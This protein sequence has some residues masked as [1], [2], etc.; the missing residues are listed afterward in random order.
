MS[1]RVFLVTGLAPRPRCGRGLAGDEAGLCSGRVSGQQW[2]H[3]L[4]CRAGTAW[5]G[6]CR[7]G[8]GVTAPG[9]GSG[10]GS[11]Q[12]AWPWLRLGGASEDHTVPG[13]A[14]WPLRSSLIMGCLQQRL[15]LHTR[16]G[17]PSDGG[18]GFMA[19]LCRPPCCGMWQ[20]RAV[21]VQG[22]NSSARRRG[23]SGCS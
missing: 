2:H 10:A 14:L 3:C 12:V 20:N 9:S 5:P 22:L 8:L 18:L 13:S 4:G 7:A 6:S 11:V 1:S 17:A 16:G 21:W 23:R 19:G 15:R